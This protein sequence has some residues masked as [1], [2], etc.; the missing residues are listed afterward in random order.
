M[1][2]SLKK[3]LWERECSLNN[4]VILQ[5]EWNIL[6][7]S[8]FFLSSSLATYPSIHSEKKNMLEILSWRLASALPFVEV[9]L[10]LSLTNHCVMRLNDKGFAW[11]K[12]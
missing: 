9:L 7:F 3:G 4:L 1:L 8:F 10:E 5:E 12:T 2:R 6:S 11:V